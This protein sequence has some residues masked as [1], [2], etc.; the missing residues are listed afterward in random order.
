MKAADSL[1]V[2]TLYAACKNTESEIV[3]MFMKDMQNPRMALKRLLPHARRLMQK[4]EPMLQKSSDQAA[5][6]FL[7]EYEC[8]EEK[9]DSSSIGKAK[10]GKKTRKQQ[11]KK[12]K[13]RC[14]QEQ[15]G[16]PEKMKSVEP[17]CVG[18]AGATPAVECRVFKPWLYK[19]GS[20]STAH[21][22]HLFA[23]QNSA[24]LLQRVPTC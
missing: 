8:D 6:E 20:W 9:E 24:L 17:V 14:G 5:A 23:M 16:V 18:V 13:E 1:G 10:K 19:E 2:G 15:K 3:P 7:L 12:K 22:T 21:F 4:M 11:K